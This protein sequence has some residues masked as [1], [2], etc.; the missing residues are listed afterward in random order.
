MAWV[1][2]RRRLGA[3]RDVARNREAMVTQRERLMSDT[4]LRAMIAAQIAAAMIGRLPPRGVDPKQIAEM[5]VAQAKE[6]EAA[7][8]RS[9]Q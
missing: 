9:F 6:I 7:T 4:Q 3:A 1:S 8:A 2:W 5:A